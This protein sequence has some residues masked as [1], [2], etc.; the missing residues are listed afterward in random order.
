[1]S[2]GHRKANPRMGVKGPLRGDRNREAIAGRKRIGRDYREK[3]QSH[4][5]IVTPS[6]LRE[7]NG[8]EYKIIHALD[9]GQA[10][11]YEH[12]REFKEYLEIRR[13][14]PKDREMFTHQFDEQL[15]LHGWGEVYT[16]LDD[17]Q[18]VFLHGNMAYA[19]RAWLDTMAP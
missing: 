14:H 13:I 3:G 12:S 17:V 10:Y 11:D 18:Y 9:R 15:R 19:I 4:T 8:N 2:G 7:F 5:K 6:P 1:M 16:G